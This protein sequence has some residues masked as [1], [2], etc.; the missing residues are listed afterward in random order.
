MASPPK[1]V[2]HAHEENTVDS[3]CKLLLLLAGSDM[4]TIPSG[5]VHCFEVKCPE[6]IKLKISSGC[7]WDVNLKMENGKIVMDRGWSEFV[8]AHD[9]KV[10]YFLVFKKLDTRSLKVLI[11]FITITA[12]SG[13]CVQVITHHWR[14]NRWLFGSTYNW[15]V[16]KWSI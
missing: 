7:I 12:R 2:R 4:R 10:G 13:S 16:E 9:L 14:K 8:K 5:F 11:F 3:F 15:H 6:K 1:Q